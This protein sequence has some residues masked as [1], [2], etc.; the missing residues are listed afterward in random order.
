MTGALLYL[1]LCTA[2]NRVLRQLRRVREPRYAVALLVGLGYLWLVLLRRGR[3]DP[4]AGAATGDSALLA[5][6]V[7]LALLVASWWLFSGERSALTFTQAEVQ[8]LF[9]APVSRR[10]LI[11]YKLLHAQ[12]VIVVSTVIWVTLLVR[13]TAGSLWLR[14]ISLWV[15]F[16]TLHLHRVGAALVRASAREQ[17]VTGLRRN[18]IPLM[19]VSAALVATAWSVVDALPTLRAAVAGGNG[20]RAICDVLR[21]P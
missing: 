5:S 11:E 10:G 20:A 18:A 16:S 12:L 1:L 7:G 9:P 8:F 2:R 14:G 21:G 13:G 4:L 17:G 3:P 19:V 6:S 15:L